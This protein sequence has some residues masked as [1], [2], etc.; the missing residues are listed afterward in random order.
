MM[1]LH[2]QCFL[3]KKKKKLDDDTCDMLGINFGATRGFRI[4]S[5][6]CVSLF[7]NLKART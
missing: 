1:M 4:R 3:S 2:Q 7:R 6:F 5:L